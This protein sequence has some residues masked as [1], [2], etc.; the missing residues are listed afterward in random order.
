MGIEPT[1][2]DDDDDEIDPPNF[3]ASFDYIFQ[4]LSLIK[5]MVQKVL[6]VY[7]DQCLKSLPH[8]MEIPTLLSSHR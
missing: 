6:R 5:G 3:F 7:V 4:K 8:S 1:V 2:V